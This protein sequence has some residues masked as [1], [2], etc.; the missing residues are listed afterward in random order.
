M[1]A[2]S[3]SPVFQV[4]DLD[5]SIVFYTEVLGFEKEFAYGE[6]PFYAGVRMGKV[7]LHLCSGAENAGRTGMGSLYAFCDE[8]D[9]YYEAI[10]AKGADIT[11]KLATWPYQMRDFQVRDIDGNLLTFGCP[12]DEDT[13]TVKES[14]Q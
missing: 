5:K 1:N 12:I 2:N 6:P 14:K 7:L 11:T 8:V 10:C 13:D 3:A 9:N 4:S